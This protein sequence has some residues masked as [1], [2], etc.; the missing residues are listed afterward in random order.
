MVKAYKTLGTARVFAKRFFHD[1]KIYKTSVGFVVEPASLR[2][3]HKSWKFV[4]RVK[5][6]RR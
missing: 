3:R 6:K 1:A 5:I 4:E 2:K